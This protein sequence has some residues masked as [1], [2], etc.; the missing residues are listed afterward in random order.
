MTLQKPQLELEMTFNY[1]HKYEMK[2]R[3]NHKHEMKKQLQ[4][5]IWNL[6]TTPSTNTNMK[7]YYFNHKEGMALKKT[8]TKKKWHY[9]C[10]HKE[11]MTF[12]LFL[13]R[14]NDITIY[15]N[16]ERND[17]TTISTNW[18]WNDQLQLHSQRRNDTTNYIQNV[19]WQ[20]YCNHKHRKTRQNR[21]LLNWHTNLC[22][23]FQHSIRR[24]E[25]GDRC[26]QLWMKQTNINTCPAYLSDLLIDH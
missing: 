5:Q 2:I 12:Q 8:Y 20:N 16:K 26:F 15:F 25:I 21:R 19:K 18:R 14:N 22:A 24:Q 1:N 6:N 23:C 9:N 7:L 13:Q 17:I 4:Q 3:L 11:E 10:I